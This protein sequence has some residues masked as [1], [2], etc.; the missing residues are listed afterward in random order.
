MSTHFWI[1]NLLAI[2]MAV[3]LAC[4]ATPAT[5]TAG[6]SPPAPDAAAL[7]IDHTTADLAQVPAHWLEE[8]KKLAFHF[9][10]HFPRLADRHRAGMVGKRS[11]LTWMSR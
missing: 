9:A 5:S 2:G 3:L 6:A 4:G 7:V 1:I 8:A 11:A 10:P